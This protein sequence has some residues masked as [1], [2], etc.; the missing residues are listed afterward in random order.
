VIVVI[1]FQLQ[2]LPLLKQH[3][4]LP[5]TMDLLLLL[6]LFSGKM[7]QIKPS[8]FLPDNIQPYLLKSKLYPSL[9]SNKYTH[10]FQT[11]PQGHMQQISN[12]K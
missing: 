4:N 3:L 2:G 9:L 11:K 8:V 10:S 7:T 1:T 6:L 5:N 12:H